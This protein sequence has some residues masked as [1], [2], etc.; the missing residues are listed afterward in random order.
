MAIERAELVIENDG[1]D[2]V[3]RVSAARA[4][5]LATILNASRGGR[6]LAAAVTEVAAH[7][8]GGTGG[9]DLGEHMARHGHRVG[10]VEALE[11]DLL[12]AHARE[13][14][15]TGEAQRICRDAGLRH[16]DVAGAC[17]VS[18]PTVVR[19]FNGQRRPTGDKGV[20]FGLRPM[21]LFAWN[22]VDT[23]I[24]R[25]FLWITIAWCRL[26]VHRERSG[27]LVAS[28]V[29][30]CPGEAAA[31]RRPRVS[32]LL[33]EAELEAVQTIGK[34]AGQMRRLIG[35]GPQA[36]ADW[37]EAADKIHQ[38]QTMILAQAAARA[39]PELFRPLGGVLNADVVG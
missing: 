15:R 2:V 28:G 36:E 7:A 26:A 1:D 38:L 39:Y 5:V 11:R 13:A 31:D 22:R 21:R 29:R 27:D 37:A 18:R 33:N 9:A 17:R 30:R 14:L 34:F 32:G 4:S 25:P 20:R 8:P 3:I 23:V 24:G 35:D 19:W 12:L 10:H 16:D 6:D